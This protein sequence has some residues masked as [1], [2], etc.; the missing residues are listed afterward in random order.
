MPIAAATT[1]TSRRAAPMPPGERRAAIIA[2]VLPLLVARGA[3]V[4][5]RE[6]AH[7]AGVS[8]GTVFNVFADKHELLAAA[9]E[10][11]VDLGPFEQAVAAID[12][13]APFERRLVLATELIQRRIVDI[14]KLISQ[15]GPEGQP[16]DRRPL[17]DSRAL[18]DLFAA[19]P[20]QVRLD[21]ADAA[22]LLRAL[23]LSLTHPMLTAEP[24][25]AAAIV[26]LFL[27]GAGREAGRP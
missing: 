7:A 2:A 10:A 18:A 4:T 9:V 22:R 21:P 17:P 8:E 1:E 23:T 15:L 11:A 26:D 25:D 3:A 27:R 19:D 24:L 5:S 6:I 14:W 12:P 20:K 16:P 13:A